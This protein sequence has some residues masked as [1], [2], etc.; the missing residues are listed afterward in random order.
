MF[1]DTC[2]KLAYLYTKKTCMKCQGAVNISI[3]I[4]CDSCSATAQ[5]CSACLKK[6]H[7]QSIN[8]IASPGCRSCGK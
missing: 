5:S 6:I 2:K 1:C 3:S 8:K 4:M 7:S